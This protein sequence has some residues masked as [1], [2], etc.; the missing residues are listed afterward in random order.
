MSAVVKTTAKPVN[1]LTMYLKRSKEITEAII[2]ASKGPLDPVSI[3]R[4]MATGIAAIAIYFKNLNCVV[5]AI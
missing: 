2:M 5:A 4:R 1:T 3:I